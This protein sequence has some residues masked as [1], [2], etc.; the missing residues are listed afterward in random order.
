[1]DEPRPLNDS[2]VALFVMAIIGPMMITGVEPGR[3]R[4]AL[5]KFVDG[6][7]YWEALQLSL[8]RGDRFGEEIIEEVERN[9]LIRE[10]QEKPQ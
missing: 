7:Q 1:M 10:H 4:A 9:H 2:D 3:I 6:D 8:K 5:K